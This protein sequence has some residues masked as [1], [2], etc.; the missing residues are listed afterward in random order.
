MTCLLLRRAVGVGWHVLLER[1]SSTI[2][3]EVDRDTNGTT[4]V[5]GSESTGEVWDEV[6]S[7]A[8]EGT[9]G[10]E[11]TWDGDTDVGGGVLCRSVSFRRESAGPTYVTNDGSVDNQG[12]EGLLVGSGVVLQQSSGVVVA[13]GL[14]GWALG[15]SEGRS[16]GDGKSLEKHDDYSEK[17]IDLVYKKRSEKVKTCSEA[18]DESD[19]WNE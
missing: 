5:C 2:V 1:S 16:G 7:G 8:V 4:S 14:V 9:V 11:D 6:D 10:V 15:D 13:H 17:S 19:G 18:V 12:E 3:E